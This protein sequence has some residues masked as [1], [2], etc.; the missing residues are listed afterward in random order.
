V[1]EIKAG[2]YF[3][4]DLINLIMADKNVGC[5]APRRGRRGRGGGMKRTPIPSTELLIPMQIKHFKFN[6]SG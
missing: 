3:F 6:C 5:I 1:E 4:I 2:K